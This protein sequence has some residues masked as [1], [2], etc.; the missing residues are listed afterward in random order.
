EEPA[1]TGPL[2]ARIYNPSLWGKSRPLSV[3]LKGTD[4]QIHVWQ[5][6][7][8]IPIGTAV[9]YEDIAVCI[10]RPKA[11]RAVG[12]AVGR[13]PVSFVIPCHRVIRKTGDFGYYGSGPVLK[14]AMLAWEAVHGVGSFRDFVR[15][16]KKI[17]ASGR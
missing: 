17:F 6:L 7:I 14:K 11:V 2:V 1:T 4:F 12:N 15:K 9:T 5:A 13:N 10:G 8:R 16:P 3:L